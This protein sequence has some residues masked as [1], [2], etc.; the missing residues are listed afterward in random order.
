MDDDMYLHALLD[1]Y[2]LTPQF[3]AVWGKVPESDPC[4]RRSQSPPPVVPG[5]SR[6]GIPGWADRRRAAAG[7][8]TV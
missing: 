1:R 8:G 2:G 7:G 4:T 5:A 3:S 6:A